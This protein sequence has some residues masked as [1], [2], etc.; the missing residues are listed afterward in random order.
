MYIVCSKKLWIFGVVVI[1]IC[2]AIYLVILNLPISSKVDKDKT[3]L[4]EPA[5][6]AYPIENLPEIANYY[7]WRKTNPRYEPL[8]ERFLPPV[9]FSQIPLDKN[10]FGN[11]L[12]NLPLKSKE[13]SVRSYDEKVILD[14]NS[15]ELAGIVDIDVGNKDLQQC[16]DF[17][18]RLRAEYLW[19]AKRFQEMKFHFTSGHIFNWPDWA[20]G[21]R[22]IVLGDTVTFTKVASQDDSRES[23]VNY[24]WKVFSYAGTISLKKDSINVNKSDIR[25]GDFFL[26]SGSPGHTVIIL[27]IAKNGIGEK[28]A[29]IGQGFMPAQDFHIL[30]NPEGEP[31]FRLD[32]TKE[33]VKTPFWKIFHWDTLRRFIE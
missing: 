24:L 13:T 18:I 1:L 22:P 28:I 11:W 5:Q 14:G 2:L 12:H 4:K 19:S 17:L 8:S 3:T 20:S 26:D 32:T 7:T 23:F 9:G 21:V 33:G 30:N 27:D 29:L 31:W 15:F 25:V 16:A 10:S 6:T